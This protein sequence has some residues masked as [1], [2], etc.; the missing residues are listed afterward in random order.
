VH[1]IKDAPIPSSNIAPPHHRTVRGND[2]SNA[3]KGKHALITPTSVPLTMSSKKRAVARSPAEEMAAV[4]CEAND[5]GNALTKSSGILALPAEIRI[6]IYEYVFSSEDVTGQVNMPGTSI[7][8]PLMRTCRLLRN[9]GVELYQDHLDAVVIALQWQQEVLERQFV[10]DALNSYMF[11]SLDQYGNVRTQEEWRVER[12]SKRIW[13][14][15]VSEVFH[16]IYS[17]GLQSS[18]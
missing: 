1:L 8:P 4:S 3:I 14:R 6:Q 2:E 5:E 7:F 10:D 9:E 12:A 13:E 16:R 15:R 11:V 17:E 18:S